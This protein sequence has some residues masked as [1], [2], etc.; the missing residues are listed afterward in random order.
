MQFL[1][2]S[3]LLSAFLI[4]LVTSSWQHWYWCDITQNIPAELLFF[5][6]G[7]R[8]ERV[9]SVPQNI[10]S[11]SSSAYRQFESQLWSV[12]S[13]LWLA[14]CIHTSAMWVMVQMHP[15]T[16][17]GGRC[18]WGQCH[19]SAVWVPL[20]LEGTSRRGLVALNL[21]VIQ[22][23]LSEARQH[24]VQKYLRNYIKEL[25]ILYFCYSYVFS[26]SQ[27]AG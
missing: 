3:F 11:R 22:F 9:D 23:D 18:R 4:E 8:I 26:Y 6:T 15:L 14:Q 13:R 1:D 17:P 16:L 10:S 2:L 7:L 25:F 5:V 24:D 21:Q 20:A 12:H 27:A 19:L